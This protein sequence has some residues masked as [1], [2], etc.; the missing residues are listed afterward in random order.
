MHYSY[1]AI[2]TYRECPQAY[3]LKYIQG[4]PEIST[5]AAAFGS[6]FH[7]DIEA[8]TLHCRA[9]N[10]D[11]DIAWMEQYAAGKDPETAELLLKFAGSH[12]I[13]HGEQVGAEYSIKCKLGGHEFHAILDLVDFCASQVVITDYKSDHR[14][15][16]ATEVASSLQMHCYAAAAATAFPDAESFLCRMDF[17]RFEKVREALF[18]REQ[19]K[20]FEAQIVDTIRGIEAA[21]EFPA[22]PGTG[23]SPFCSYQNLCRAVKAENVEVVSNK[24]QAE[25]AAAQL[26]ALEARVKALKIPLSSWCSKNG[27]VVVNGRVAGYFPEERF[28]YS[29]EDLKKVCDERGYDAD[30]YLKADTSAL[31]DAAK[32]DP[33]FDQ[34]MRLIRVD[35]SRTSFKTKK[36]VGA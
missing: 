14:L 8:Y 22:T 32:D 7:A 28:E 35:K 33:E 1:T 17:A 3:E 20:G 29:K 6:N 18:T 24:Q 34:A 26:F 23:C 5:E 12:L 36:V 30:D 16:P 19:A 13:P 31:K 11:G 27:I 9:A 10:T 25:D 2:K 21:V 4:L 15:R